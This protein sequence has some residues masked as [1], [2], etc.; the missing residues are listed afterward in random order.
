MLAVCSTHDLP[1]STEDAEIGFYE[2]DNT[3]V[4]VDV[5]QHKAC[6]IDIGHSWYL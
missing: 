5:E 2:W 4:S 1:G 6:L 3:E